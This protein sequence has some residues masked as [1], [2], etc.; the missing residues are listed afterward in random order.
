VPEE[1]NKTLHTQGTTAA[2]PFVLIVILNWNGAAETL[3]AV[4]SVAQMDYQNYRILIIDNGS[5][6]DSLTVLRGIVNDRVELVEVPV[7]T[8]Y[9]GG[10][11]IGLKRA[12]EINAGY[13]WLLNSDA[14]TAP[15]TLSSLVAL[16]ESDDRIGLVSP[17]IASHG[18]NPEIVF[19]GSLWDKN[20]SEYLPRTTD[21]E[22]AKRWMAEYPN[23]GLVWGTALLVPAKVI[24][25]IG[26]L[27]NK[28]FA[29]YEDIDY[30]V[31]SLD[32]GYRNIVDQASIIY[33]SNKDM[34]TSPQSLTPHY[35][36]YMARN[37]RRFLRK[38]YG[39]IKGLRLSWWRT[40]RYMQHRIRLKADP[41][42]REAILAGIWHG[43]L[44]KIGP[45]S[46]GLHAPRL[47]TFLANK[48]ETRK[49]LQPKS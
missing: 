3:A 18:P 13:V 35:W 34:D 17:L 44:C 19:A 41:I 48:Y 31:R 33:H 22:V 36:Y 42:A 39:E 30:A 27:D 47:I 1:P 8:G 32:A 11:N 46:P 43:W 6:D 37:E 38:H 20:G 24:R 9:T 2:Q 15:D 16:A 45:Y 4:E 49:S 7:N 25:K 5:T 26:L 29:Y 10:C 23:S 12:L 28:F 40:N 21:T 14:V